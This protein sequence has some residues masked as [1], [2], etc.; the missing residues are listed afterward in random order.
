MK[1]E[2][3]WG[4]PLMTPGPLPVW[5]HL[6]NAYHC[7]GAFTTGEAMVLLQL[8]DIPTGVVEGNTRPGEVWASNAVIAGR[9]NQDVRTVQRAVTKAR[10]F[11]LLVAVQHRDGMSRWR[12]LPCTE[13]EAHD[14]FTVHL[15][16]IKERAHASSAATNKRI[17]QAAMA[18]SANPAQRAAEIE[19]RLA[20]NYAAGRR[21]N[22]DAEAWIVDTLAP[23]VVRFGLHESWRD[24]LI[25]NARRKAGRPLR[26]V[27]RVRLVAGYSDRDLINEI[28]AAIK[29]TNQPDQNNLSE[30]LDRTAGWMRNAA[31]RR[32][33]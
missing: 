6:I 29:A 23:L 17:R 30:W 3:D 24:Q 1:P 14:R 26:D 4:T 8:D 27:V 12:A 33:A 31:T 18:G 19:A 16:T 15:T 10:R 2:K 7:E 32:A 13:A 11:G 28:V 9:A 5:R 22:Q 25:Q 20:A 21:R